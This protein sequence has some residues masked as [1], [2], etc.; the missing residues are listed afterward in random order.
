MYLLHHGIEAAGP[1]QAL[2]TVLAR[3]PEVSHA[4]IFGSRASGRARR[5]SGI[6]LA[7]EAPGLAP[8]RWHALLEDLEQAPVIYK[9]DIVRL[10]TLQ[11]P[12]LQA[13]I[14]QNRAPLWTKQ[15]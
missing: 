11:A 9:L 8:V 7:I 12:D 5:T 13:A 1:R 2:Q 4:W 10:D 6:D 15:E 3:F 14:R